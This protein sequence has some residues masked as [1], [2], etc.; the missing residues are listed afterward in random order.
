MSVH[1][2]ADTVAE[3]DEDQRGF[4][5]ALAAWVGEVVPVVGA[6]LAGAAG[7]PSAAALEEGLVAAAGVGWAASR[8]KAVQGDLFAVADALEKD[9]SEEWVRAAAAGV[10]ADAAPVATPALLA[11]SRVRS[12]LILTTNYDLAIETAALEAEVPTRTLTLENFESALADDHRALR[13]VHLHGVADRPE[14]V[15]LGSRSYQRVREDPRMRLLVRAVSTR[16]R[17]LF[18]GHSLAAREAH[19]RRD[20]LWVTQTADGG[21]PRHLLLASEPDRDSPDVAAQAQELR[22]RAGVRQ[23]VFPDPQRRFEAAVRAAHVLAGPSTVAAGD[24]APALRPEPDRLYLPVP[25]AR[26]RSA[27]DPGQRGSWMAR[28]WQHGPVFSN[29]LDTVP[30]LLLVAGGGFGKS[31]ELR[32]IGRRSGRPALVQTLTSLHP[33]DAGLDPD[34]DPGPAFVRGMAEAQTPQRE[35]VRRLD[36]DRLATESYMFLLDGLDEVGAN[37]R[38]DV[39]AF[40]AA[41]ARR[42]PQHRWVVTSRPVPDLDV[43]D[44]LFEAWTPIPDRPWL[45][46]YARRRGVPEARLAEVLGNAP[47]LADLVEIP[48]YAAAAVDSAEHG[49]PL[50]RTA[51]SLV[52]K[53]ADE[54]TRQDRRLGDS[55]QVGTWLDRLALYL[56]I[57]GRTEISVDDLARTRL[58][59]GLNRVAPTP[60]LLREL[61]VRA[62]LTDHGGTVRFPANI[63]LEARAARALLAAGNAGLAYL[64]QRIIVRLPTGPGREVRTLRPSWTGT[65]ELA[66]SEAPPAWR[67]TVAAV[68]P[69]LAARSVPA[70]AAPAERH[71]A[72]ATIW[73]TYTRRRVWLDSGYSTGRDDAGSLVRLLKTDSTPDMLATLTAATRSDE[74]SLRA[75]ALIALLGIGHPHALGIAARLVADPHPVV[76]RH[77]ASAALDLGAVDLADAIAAQAGADLD[78]M[79]RQ[80]LADVA[81]SLAAD[82]EHAIRLAYAMPPRVSGH[83]VAALATRLSRDRALSL[84]AEQAPLDVRLLAAVLPDGYRHGQTPWTAADAV[85]LGRLAAAVPDQTLGMDGLDTVLREHPEAVLIARAAAPPTNDFDF[86]MEDLLAGLPDDRLDELRTVLAGTAERI[87]ASG[88]APGGGTPRLDSLARLRA[89]ADR[90][91]TAR[92]SPPPAFANRPLL[93]PARPGPAR[94]PS[95]QA[96]FDVADWPALLAWGPDRAKPALDG[97]PPPAGL[98]RQATADLDRL[99]ADDPD[100]LVRTANELQDPAGRTLRWAAALDL[101]VAPSTVPILAEAA[102]R[103]GDPQ[104]R[105]W[106]R[107]HWH[108]DAWP[109]LVLRLPALGARQIALH[110][111]AIPAPWPPGLADAVLD[112]V[113]DPAL[114]QHE[115]G[116]AAEQARLHASSDAVLAWAPSPPPGWLL[117]VLAAAGHPNAERRLV[118]GLAATTDPV[119]RLSAHRDHAWLAHV[120]QPETAP[121]LESAARALMTTA[122]DGDDLSALFDALDRCAGPAALETYDRLIA[123]PAL[124]NGRWLIYQQ[125]RS[126]AA[127]AEAAAL[128]ALPPDDTLQR[129]VVA[130]FS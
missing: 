100:A 59:D 17:L 58:H 26:G 115:R 84:L 127:F 93:R 69:L 109:L 68:D 38:S 122:R 62:L 106:V 16:F 56:K 76:R 7:V 72:A 21:D 66:L 65:I 32:Q 57:G 99:L 53:L 114:D 128:G 48:V 116:Q 92:D 91:R 40:V 29:G 123:E 63:V 10:V 119:G 47:G 74:P 105:R 25:V 24:Q 118:E 6:G 20:V 51:L 52:L 5:D 117:P 35:P 94:R 129:Q 13:V 44:D 18:L 126:E 1:L 23:V 97:E 80:T 14:T 11:L 111:D 37:R 50:P 41:L 81:I 33:E 88:V 27:T 120:R 2:G 8:L 104:L 34:S 77:A 89:A 82:D 3:T 107:D 28:V 78:E 95:P 30:R 90:F 15:V 110:A 4:F 96:L 9:F 42:Y 19:L 103:R 108:P 12:G 46:E 75:N 31:E 85:R 79:A 54:R 43:F 67:K 70:E 60:E 86:D 113:L 55:K 64:E 36:Y 98:M 49:T 71:A 39:A 22:N 121:A 101:N 124:P 102:I 73:S 125:Q 112:A 130:G 45:I 87:A 83:A 61:A